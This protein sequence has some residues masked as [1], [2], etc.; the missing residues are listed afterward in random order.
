MGWHRTEWDVVSKTERNKKD[1]KNKGYQQN[2]KNVEQEKEDGADNN[3][4]HDYNKD[5][6]DDSDC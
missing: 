6:W 2:R 5:Y 1:F 3:D 4:D